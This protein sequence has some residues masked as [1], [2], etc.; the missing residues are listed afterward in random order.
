M[1]SK[2]KEMLSDLSEA[3]NESKKL[4]KKAAKCS[5]TM[6]KEISIRS[7]YFSSHSDKHPCAESLFKLDINCNLVRFILTILVCMILVS[8]YSVAKRKLR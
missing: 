4:Y 7:S 3:A 1:Q 6:R 2:T 5:P 8:I